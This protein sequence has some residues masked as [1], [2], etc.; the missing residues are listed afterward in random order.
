MKNGEGED[1][2]KYLL[3]HLYFISDFIP[4]QLKLPDVAI[5][6]QLGNC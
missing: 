1:P 4:L 5:E 6:L 3:S 2:I